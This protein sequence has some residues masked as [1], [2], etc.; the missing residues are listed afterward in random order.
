MRWAVA[1][2][3]AALAIPVLGLLVPLSSPPEGRA[4]PSEAYAAATDALF[5]GPFP[6][7]QTAADRVDTILA[8]RT[9]GYF[10]AL[11]GGR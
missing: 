10:A 1:F 11:A 8:A 9:R 4:L 7:D 5:S 3:A 6:E 2:V